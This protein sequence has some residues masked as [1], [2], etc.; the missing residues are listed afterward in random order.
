MVK[1]ESSNKKEK[2]NSRDENFAMEI[3]RHGLMIR[4]L[5]CTYDKMIY[6]YL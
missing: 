3:A 4:E 6:R 5:L 1:E 2:H